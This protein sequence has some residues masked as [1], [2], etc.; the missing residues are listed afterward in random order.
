VGEARSVLTTA[1][2]LPQR[3]SCY[4]GKIV[5][6]RMFTN[7]KLSDLH[8]TTAQQRFTG[9][10]LPS[11]L[12][13]VGYVPWMMLISV[14]GG[15]E[16]KLLQWEHCKLLVFEV[17]RAMT[18]KT[19]GFKDVLPYSQVEVYRRFGRTSFLSLRSRRMCRDCRNTVRV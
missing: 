14:V 7:L 3:L 18:M 9:Q 16:Y 12:Y 13:A 2:L 4:W 5:S 6:L 8:L 15:N 1:I 17:F 19:T 11:D 10:N